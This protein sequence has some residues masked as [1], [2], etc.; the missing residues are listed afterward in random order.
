MG[1]EGD[2]TGA[3]DVLRD[4]VTSIEKLQEFVTDGE[5]VIL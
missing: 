5:I 3:D 4:M 1:R 2:L